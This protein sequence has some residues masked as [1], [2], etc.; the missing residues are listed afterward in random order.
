[1]DIDIELAGTDATEKVLFSMQDWLKNEKI[2]E[3][4]ATR[5]S[6]KPAKGHMG[7]DPATILSIVLGSAAIVKLVESIHVWLKT[8]RPNINVKIKTPNGNIEID[9][10][11]L[12]EIDT[13]ID[14][15][16]ALFP[17]NKE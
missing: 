16:T 15:A 1:M 13:L 5:K 14:K 17:R 4:K 12:P 11:N 6:N 3:L 7:I 2:P 10:Q 9:A 8:R